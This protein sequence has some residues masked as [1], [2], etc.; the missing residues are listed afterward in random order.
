MISVS[1]SQIDDEVAHGYKP[2]AVGT[3]RMRP[4]NTPS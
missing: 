3:G 1:Q 2:H 4:A